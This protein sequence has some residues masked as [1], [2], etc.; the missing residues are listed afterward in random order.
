MRARVHLH[1]PTHV[2]AHCFGGRQARLLGMHLEEYLARG[3][4]GD[5]PATVDMECD[6]IVTMLYRSLQPVETLI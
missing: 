5:L 3:A 4:A 6:T 1:T 2:R